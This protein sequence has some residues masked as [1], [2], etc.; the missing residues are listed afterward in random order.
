[1]LHRNR[2]RVGTEYAMSISKSFLNF[3]FCRA[4]MMENAIAMVSSCMSRRMSVNGVSTPSTRR[5]GNE[6]T[7]RCRSDAL[8][9]TAIFRRSL[10]C[11]DGPLL[12][13]RVRR[14]RDEGKDLEQEVAIPGAR[15]E[16]RGGD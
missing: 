4:D 15:G 7:F 12:P 5:T 11:M 2:P 10:M 13:S 1:M 9:S 14:L 16:V 8:R 3:S 6:L